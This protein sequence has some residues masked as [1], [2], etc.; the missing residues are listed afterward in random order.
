MQ[1][2][3]SL[4]VMMLM[5]SSS[6]LPSHP[7]CP[8][9]HPSTKTSI[10]CNDPSNGSAVVKAQ[11][12]FECPT[13]QRVAAAIRQTIHPLRYPTP[14]PMPPSERNSVHHRASYKTCRNAVDERSRGCRATGPEPT[15]RQAA[16]ATALAPHP[17]CYPTPPPTRPSRGTCRSERR[18]RGRGGQ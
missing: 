13:V 14:P 7:T 8:P 4:R 10:Q 17:P 5:A 18:L 3:P 12:S 11:C 2:M 1:V 6:H 15:A 9:A 16:V